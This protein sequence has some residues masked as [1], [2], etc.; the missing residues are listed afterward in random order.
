M[1]IFFDL[2][3]TQPVK[4][5]KFHGGGEYAKAVFKRLILNKKDTDVICFYDKNRY[6]DKDILNIVKDNQL[7]LLH[8][9]KKEDIQKIIISSMVDKVYSAL[10]YQF[11]DLNFGDL[12][13]IYT[14]HG[15]RAIEMPTDYYEFKYSK[16]IR[17][18]AKY[19]FKNVFRKKYISMKKKQFKK[20]FQIS[21]NTKVIVPSQHT[22][23]ALLCNFPE[24]RQEKIY[25]LYSPK[26]D[27]TPISDDKKLQDFTL[28]ER[29][30]FLLISANRWIKN[31]YRAIHALDE[32]FSEFPDLTKKVLVLGMDKETRTMKINNKN[33]FVFQGYVERNVLEMLYKTA[34]CFIYPSLNE[35]F[36]YPPL[37]CMKY[38]TPVISS[39]ITSIPEICQ[40]GALYFNP[41]SK[42]EM[43]GRVLQ[44]VFEPDVYKRYSQRGIEVAKIVS[45]KQDKMLDKLIDII[46]E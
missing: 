1:R 21:S 42:K 29:E 23:Y 35:G 40:D 34:Y 7:E 44:L 22:K 30:F 17:D 16:N 10:P 24:L 8:I 45:K 3:A 43:K 18:I 9:E 12:E 11:Y 36:G 46:L 20:I 39:A 5:S 31:S 28:K 33:Q 13:F 27:T 14:I 4:E 37:E 6:F 15:L 41:F 2:M 25:V 26:E 32:L 38:G 19:L